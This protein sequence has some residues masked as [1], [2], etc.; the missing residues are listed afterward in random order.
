MLYL[1]FRQTYPGGQKVISQNARLYQKFLASL[2][3]EIYKGKGRQKFEFKK[4]AHVGINLNKFLE[5][6]TSC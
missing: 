2:L 5:P 1:I 4:F 6:D 3:S